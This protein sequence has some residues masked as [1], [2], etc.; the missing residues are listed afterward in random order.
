VSLEAKL[1]ETEYVWR[2][3]TRIE[4]QEG[5]GSPIHFEQSQ[6]GGAVLSA[7]R[8]QRM[9]ADFV[10]VLSE[11]GRLRRRAFELMDGKRS[12]EEVARRLAKEF[13]QRFPDWQRA[14]TY[15]GT[16]SQEYSR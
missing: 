15:A 4:T 12:L 8:L 11:E 14:L 5:S 3:T 6:L 2:W 13:P 9:A 10:P 1:V 16:I 7:K